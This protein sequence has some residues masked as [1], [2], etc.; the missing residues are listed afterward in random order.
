MNDISTEITG[1]TDVENILETAIRE[2]GIALRTQRVG[3]RLDRSSGKS[4]SN[5]NK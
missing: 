3:I 2:V 5:G 1:Q 4:L